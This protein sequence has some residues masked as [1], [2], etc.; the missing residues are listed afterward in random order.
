MDI[1]VPVTAAG[2]EAFSTD[3]NEL[4]NILLSRGGV[5]KTHHI[6]DAEV[7]NANDNSSFFYRDP[8]ICD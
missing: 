2:N 5:L 8:Q 1:D 6:D 4:R 3:Q 7:S